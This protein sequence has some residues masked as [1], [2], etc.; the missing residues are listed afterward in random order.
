L[1][2]TGLGDAFESIDRSGKRALRR[3]AEYDSQRD[4]A[5]YSPSDLP[6]ELISKMMGAVAEATMDLIVSKPAM[7]KKYREGG[8]EI[9]WAGIAR[10]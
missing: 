5:A 1:F 9:D 10:K 6:T 3:D 7:A 2:N 8:F 4:G